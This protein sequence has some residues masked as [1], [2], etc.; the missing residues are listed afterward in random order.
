M[1]RGTRQEETEL[2]QK[3]N[4]VHLLLLIVCS[5]CRN[6]IGKENKFRTGTGWRFSERHPEGLRGYGPLPVGEGKGNAIVACSPGC[7]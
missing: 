2:E 1:G 3:R 4:R 5:I 6:L 7:V